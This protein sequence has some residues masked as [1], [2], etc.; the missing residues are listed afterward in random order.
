M[1]A[2][3]SSWFFGLLAFLSV[4]SYPSEVSCDILQS[5]EADTHVMQILGQIATNSVVSMLI[6]YC[7]VCAAYL[8]FYKR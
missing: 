8:S 5:V 1:G 3:L 4:N 2:V 7:T 6:A